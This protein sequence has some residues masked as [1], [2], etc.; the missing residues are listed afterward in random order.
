MTPRGQSRV[1]VVHTDASPGATGGKDFYTINCEFE[2]VYVLAGSIELLFTDRRVA[3]SAGDALTF[4]GAEPHTWL[5]PSPTEAAELVWVLT[6]APW[7]GS[8]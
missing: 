1:Q 8:A 4:P 2:V 6:P 3:L 5:N 7:S